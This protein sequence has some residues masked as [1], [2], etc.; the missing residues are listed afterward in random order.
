[1]FN[2]TYKCTLLL[3]MILLFSVQNSFSQ[4][5]TIT[6]NNTSFTINTASQVSTSNTITSS[7]SVNI[8]S[9]SST[10]NLYATVLSKSYNPTST[11]FSPLPLNLLLNNITGG[12]NT[13]GA[14]TG[15]I[16][17]ADAPAYATLGSNMPKTGK[18][19]ATWN[20]N[21]VLLPVNFTTQPGTYVFTIQL[22]LNAGGSVSNA[23]FNV[24]VNVQSVLSIALQQNSSSS[25]TF[26]SSTDYTNGMTLNNFH[27]LQVRSNVP[28]LVSV[29]APSY[30]TPA[31]QGA[32]ANM[33]SSIMG[34]KASTASS[35]LPLSTSAQTI[36]TGIA[37]DISASG[38]TS[39]F[40]MRFH[41]SYNYSAGIYNISL[42][43]TLTG[44]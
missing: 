38:N 43:Y 8:S 36:K 23:T 5:L 10:Y 24:T 11:V 34:I 29:T 28:W 16:Q 33:P 18:N 6:S 26:A 1:M 42:T 44:Q 27:S 37:G 40:D 35:F 7:F 9:S 21:L 41:P 39:N 4:S 19:G 20:Y 15:N 12:G 30:F 3:L 14:I 31:S 2:W 13:S 25:I 17:V 22:Q 32:D